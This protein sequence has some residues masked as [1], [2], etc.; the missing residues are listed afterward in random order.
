MTDERRRVD[1]EEHEAEADEPPDVEMSDVARRQQLTRLPAVVERHREPLEIRVEVVAHRRLHA[2]RGV[3]HHAAAEE[4]GGRLDGAEAEHEARERPDAGAV[5]VGDRAVDHRLGDEGDD[6]GRAQADEGGQHHRQQ[7]PHVG[8]D[9]GPGAPERDEA[10]TSPKAVVR[11]VVRGYRRHRPGATELP[12]GQACRRSLDEYHR[13]SHTR[14][15]DI[16][17]GIG[18]CAVQCTVE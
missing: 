8:A 3:G 17:D 4:R 18:I 14:R 2:E 11:A 7:L 13:V 5:A 6:R 10:H 9:I 16:P 15:Y 12:P 1:D